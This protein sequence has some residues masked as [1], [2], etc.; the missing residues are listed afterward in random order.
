MKTG[1]FG[2]T[3]K[4]AFFKGFGHQQSCGHG[5]HRNSYRTK[6]KPNKYSSFTK[7]YHSLTMQW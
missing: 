7:K 5:C 2:M 4:K 1:K 3:G 6:K